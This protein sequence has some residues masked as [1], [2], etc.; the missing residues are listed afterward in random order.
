M[1]YVH[2]SA[3][4]SPGDIVDSLESKKTYGFMTNNYFLSA[5]IIADIYKARWDIELFYKLNSMGILTG[6]FAA[7]R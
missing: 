1:L 3:K 4:K 7:C 2:M 5:K 6:Y